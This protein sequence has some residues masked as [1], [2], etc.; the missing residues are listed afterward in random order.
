MS[1]V[2]PE[3]TA[4]SVP[5]A[6]AA[7]VPKSETERKIEAIFSEIMKRPALAAALL[8]P[9]S[10]PE[11]PP[12]S[13][14]AA[15]PAP[16]VDPILILLA[17]MQTATASFPAGETG[18]TRG[19][20]QL[21]ERAATTDATT[22]ATF[23]THV[24][25]LL[26]DTNRVLGANAIEMPTALSAEMTKLAATSPGLTNKAMA[27]MLQGTPDIGDRGL[28]RDLRRAAASMATMGP[29]QDSAAV[30]PIIAAFE[31]RVRLAPREVGAVQQSQN[32]MPA[33]ATDPRTEGQ[34][35]STEPSSRRRGA[36]NERVDVQAIASPG[37]GGEGKPSAEGNA[38]IA[39]P[40]TVQNQS[41]RLMSHI[42]SGLSKGPVSGPAPWASPA[43]SM[44]ERMSG[45]GQR[46]D[47]GRTDQLIRSAEKSGVAYINAIETFSVG[48]GAEVLAKIDAAGSTEPGGLTT[49]MQQMQPGGRYANLRTEFDGA[50]QTDRVFAAAYSQVEKTG[51][52]Y[53]KDR[54]AVTTDFDAKKL[55]MRQLDAR[56]QKAEEAI[57]DATERIP[58][59]AP[60][61]NVTDELGQKITEFLKRAVEKVRSMFGQEAKPE[62]RSSAGPNMGPQ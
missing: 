34:T 7:T 62:Q 44:E 25:Y 55:D 21:A 42:M 35:N 3:T 38:P 8:T 39:S 56:F 45:L 53:G 26:Q 58:G 41:K 4:A 43:V 10:T 51:Q 9:Q 30:S 32:I 22:D 47:A 6:A 50:L 29:E 57:G 2:K 18:L 5:P 11:V 19:I 15:E 46:L 16:K 59:R 52:Q 23:R 40:T 61:T 37:N 36:E 20:N 13:E 27:A 33:S 1:D 24:A 28:V 12:A 49:V 48:A 17:R 31:N 54:L 14:P 60:G